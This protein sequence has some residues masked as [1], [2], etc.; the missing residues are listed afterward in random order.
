MRRARRDA[1]CRYSAFASAAYSALW[2]GP[3]LKTEMRMFESCRPEL[4]VL[5]NSDS[6][7]QR[8]ESRRPQPA[9]PFL[10]HTEADRARNATG[11]TRHPW[12]PL[13]AAG[14]KGGEEAN[15]LPSKSEP[16]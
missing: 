3:D 13:R 10:T 4:R 9:S 2:R 6:E 1:S 5:A 7:M 16:G 14:E 11:S 12:S 8:F 15:F